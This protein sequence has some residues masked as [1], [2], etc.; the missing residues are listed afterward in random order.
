MGVGEVVP[1]KK[2]LDIDLKTEGVVDLVVSRGIDANVA[3]ENCADVA[4]VIVRGEAFVLVDEADAETEFFINAELVPEGEGVLGK[5]A[6]AKAGV[7]IVTFEVAVSGRD[8]PPISD[9]AIELGF[10]APNFGFDDDEGTGVVGI[11]LW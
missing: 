3:R 9:E 4:K 7:G 6:E 10:D 11:D 5:F 1:I 2:V 8:M